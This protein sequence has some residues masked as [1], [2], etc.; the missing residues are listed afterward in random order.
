MITT[1][2][3]V[4][5]SST[6]GQSANPY[7]QLRA[8]GVSVVL[9]T[10]DRRLPTVLHW[11]AD[12]GELPAEQLEN[13]ARAAKPPYGD[14]PFDVANQVNVIPEHAS[15]WIGRPG[16][17][18][19][20]AGRDW[21]ATFRT[22]GQRL[23]D[24]LDGGQRFVAE[25]ADPVAG[26]EIV[27]ELELTAA[28][29]IRLRA[30]LTNVAEE[31]YTVGALRLALPVPAEA[32]ELMDFTG[33]H[34]MERIPQRRA[35]TV[36]VHSR[37]VRSGRTGLDSAHVL[38]AG[39]PGF[40]FRSGEVWGVHLAWSGNQVVYGERLYNGG[41]LLGGGELLDHGEII[42][43]QG[44]SYASP[45]LYGNYGRGLD[46]IAGR[47]HRHLRS[48][49][50]HPKTPRPV[51]LNTWEAVYFRQNLET[52]KK[53]A[54][55]GAA[56][57]VERFVLDDGWFAGRRDDTSS[58][59]DWTVSPHVWPEGLGPLIDYV[60]SLG[61]E[62]GL[63]V[64]P[65]MVNLDSD[66]ARAHPEWIFSAGGRTGLASRYQHVLDLGHEGAY[67][68]VRESL[69]ALLTE[70]DIAYLKW[71]H[72]RYL[73][74]A[75]HTPHGEA[76]V[77]DH[78][79]AAYRLMDQLRAAHPGLEIE[80]CAG[81]GGRIDLGVIEHTDRVWASD[82]IDPLERQQIV[83]YTQLLL[84]PELIGTHIG[85][86]HSHTTLR[87]HDLSF[88][89]ATALWGH[90]GIEWDLATLSDAEL[91][92]LGQWVAFHK[93]I[94]GLLHS[95]TVVNADHPDTAIWVSGVV[96]PDA[97]EALY[98]V[99]AVRRSVTWPPGRVRLPGLDPDRTYRVR[100]EPISESALTWVHL[101]SWVKAGGV[102]LTGRVL[103]SAGIE[104][105][106]IH[107]EHSYLLRLTSS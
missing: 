102:D 46:E 31:P 13:L 100:V 30:T 53:L 23:E 101:P 85:S 28:G 21:S 14:S 60:H 34:T 58:L 7:V 5:R 92:E 32:D 18:G 75:G 40:G 4:D 84:P 56:I 37:E 57:G 62:F 19:S 90:M 65:E 103:A 6:P 74:D 72:N 45:W 43:G 49:P 10:A 52:L 47:F 36:G 1:G 61:M 69:D 44:E 86:A 48:R 55:R 15:A 35:F 105:L 42:L 107:P 27:V 9:D 99:T 54:E 39:R 3:G 12:L 41:R 83:R 67:E 38:A 89:G 17:E 93:Q 11:G 33:R 78:T 64:E 16:V 26:L 2:Q 88:R 63:W 82:C 22:T 104:I 29:L 80:S 50:M 79:A 95:G 51:I 77:H 76:G 24:L 106:P 59:G 25:A 97:S 96:A 98:G 20:R 91:T 87:H 68:H 73:N 81:G 8:G 94:R 66:V 71:D 70:Y